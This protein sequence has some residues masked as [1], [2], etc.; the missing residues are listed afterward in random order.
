VPYRNASAGRDRGSLVQWSAPPP[1]SAPRARVSTKEEPHQAIAD[2][3]AEGCDKETDVSSASEASMAM[4]PAISIDV[5]L[6]V[7]LSP[8]FPVGAFAFSHGL[9]LAADRCWVHNRDSLEAWLRDLVE[10]GSLRND[11]ILLASAWRATAASD[12]AALLGVNELAL[13][14]QPS[15]ERRLETATQGTAFLATLAAAWP[16]PPLSAVSARIAA[17]AALPVAVGAGTAAHAIDLEG[18][19]HAFAMAFATNLVSAAIRLSIVGQ[20]DG[21]RVIAALTLALQRQAAA[22]ATATLDTIG[23]ATLRSDLASLAHETQ[24]SRLFRS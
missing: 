10:L 22:A 2:K 13:A 21:Q 19:L 12:M 16:C 15:A 11:L 1:G 6:Q 24:Y 7:W 4:M 23:S 14:L 9:E 5:R 8:S 3:V 20:T 18:T 17:E